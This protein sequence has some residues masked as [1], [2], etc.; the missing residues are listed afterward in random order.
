MISEIG[1]CPTEGNRDTHT[2]TGKSRGT[3]HELT[4]GHSHASLG[5][6]ASEYTLEGATTNRKVKFEEPATGTRFDGDHVVIFDHLLLFTG[7]W[8]GY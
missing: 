2:D 7:K 1:A 6:K 3:Y 5:V 4:P 8:D